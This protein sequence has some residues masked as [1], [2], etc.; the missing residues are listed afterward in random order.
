MKKIYLSILSLAV[1]ATASAQEQK[2]LVSRSGNMMQEASMINH[3]PMEK[4]TV[5][6]SDDIANLNNWTVVNTGTGTNATTGWYHETNPAAI[7]VSTI[8]PFAST[9]A[10]NGFMMVN[11]DANNTTD[12]DG[13]V[14]HSEIT[15]NTIDLSANTNVVLRFQQNFRWWKDTRTVS[16]SGD[17]GATWTDYLI[18][19]QTAYDIGIYQG[20]QSSL[21]PDLVV[22]DI[23]SVAGGSAQVQI[24]F[25][26]DDNDI[27]AWYW[28]ID[29]VEIIAKPND[30]IQVL[31]AF[32]VDQ[33]N[34]GVEYGR[35]PVD[36]VGTNWEV[37]AQVFNFGVND[38]T[39]VNVTSVEAGGAFSYT[40]TRALHEAD[41]TYIISTVEMPTLPVGTYVVDYT[42]V[43]DGET[44]ASPDF[45]DNTAQ[46]TFEVTNWEYSIDGIGVYPAGGL[47]SSMGTAS[48]QNA[49]DNLII[50]S[51]YNFKNAVTI[52]SIKAMIS[53]TTVAG[54][55]VF[56]LII[57]T[58][59]LLADNPTPLF[60]TSSSYVVTAQDVTN[61][62]IELNFDITAQPSLPAGSYYAA[63]ELLSNGNSTDISILNDERVAQPFSGSM[64][65]IPNDQTYSN[66]VASAVRMVVQDPAFIGLNENSLEGVSVYPNPSQ[67]VI[68]VS[69]ANNTE[70]T[71]VV[72]DM[73]GKV[74]YS[75]SANSSTTIDLSSNGTGVYMVKVS[76]ENGSMVERVVIK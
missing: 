7:P 54:A 19:D 9:S 73:V 47:I 29:D 20:N 69:N 18:S 71:I 23:S 55:E 10:A 66:G 22:I 6:W 26:Y 76:N 2:A 72:Y 25:T 16:V 8:S 48:F 75:T 43:S 17:N 70:N 49:S 63:V 11:S 53:S 12:N 21:N 44:S 61:G 58:A 52:K 68:T 34:E 65:Y 45:G 38:Q 33:S 42:A 13:S 74:V 46:R 30:D 27:W 24:K 41:S 32:I 67:G 5:L 51:K 14:I 35:T 57:D 28:A 62:F 31:S 39:N 40:A 37:G 36:Q 4:A 64:I 3:I 50:A 59:D 1:L 56:G 60:I 15:S